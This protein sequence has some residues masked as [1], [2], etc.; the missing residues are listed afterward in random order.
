M[1]Q[2]F[3]DFLHN[4]SLF[5]D[6]HAWFRMHRW[7]HWCKLCKNS[8]CWHWLSNW[9]SRE[10]HVNL[11]WAVNSSPL[12]TERRRYYYLTGWPGLASLFQGSCFLSHSDPQSLWLWV[13]FRLYA[14]HASLQSRWDDLT[15]LYCP[16]TNQ[17]KTDEKIAWL[18]NL[19]LNTHCG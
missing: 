11:L 8:F 19:R 2:Q 15:Y 7:Q 4:I 10:Y 13:H 17:T 12:C 18:E 6:F 16:F 1:D 9:K 5:E 3:H 14:S